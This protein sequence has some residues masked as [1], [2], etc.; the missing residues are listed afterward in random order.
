MTLGCVVMVACLAV[1]VLAL[2]GRV[3]RLQRD[4]DDLAVRLN[5]QT[6]K[7]ERVI[8]QNQEP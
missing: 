8:Q 6:T 1:L 4:A 5:A 7:L 3:W 2:G